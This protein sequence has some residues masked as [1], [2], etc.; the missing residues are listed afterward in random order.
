M[1]SIIASEWM[2]VLQYLTTRLTQIEWEMER[3]D[4][5]SEPYGLEGSLRRLHPWRR[6][7][8]LYQ[9]WVHKILRG[10]LYEDE[11][12]AG[13]PADEALCKLRHD[14]STIQEDLETVRLQLE[15]MV[16]VVTTIMALEDNRR[17]NE[18]NRNIARLTYLGVIFVPLSFVSSFLSMTSDVT[19]LSQ[20]IWIYFALAIPI[21]VIALSILQWGH[22]RDWLARLA[23][24]RI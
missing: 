2:T 9:K 3:P 12:N 23:K 8:P 16:R 19:S 20:T 24:K 10:V 17:S 21:T 18:Q 14:F 5:R 6:A 7:V 11:I 1:L 4:F 13:R 22:I 15:S